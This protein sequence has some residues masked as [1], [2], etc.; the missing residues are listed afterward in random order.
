MK[1]GTNFRLPVYYFF[2]FANLYL[3]F[4]M[5]PGCTGIYFGPCVP[6]PDPEPDPLYIICEDPDPDPSYV[7]ATLHS[8]VY[9]LENTL[10]PGGGG[11]NIS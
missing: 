7:P 3:L 2:I 6:G 9:I 4:S 11:I 8:G 5:Y 1:V 10:P